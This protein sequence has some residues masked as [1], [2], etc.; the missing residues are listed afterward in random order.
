MA[1]EP[2]TAVLVHGGFVDGS[3]WQGVYN[4]LRRTAT[5]SASFRTRRRRW[6]TTSPRPDASSTA[7][8]ARSILVG[9]SYGGVVITEAGNDPRSQGSSTSPRSRRTRASRSPRSSRTRRPARRCRRSCRRRTDFCSSTRTKFPPR[10]RRTCEPE[11]RVHGRLAGALGRRGTQR[12]DHEAGVEDQAE[13]VPGRD[14]GQDDPAAGAAIHVR[15]ARAST[16]EEAA[17][18]HAIY[19]SKPKAVA[20]IIEKA[21]GNA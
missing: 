8:M 19:V 2:G 13:L 10:S 5:P 4:I 17:G 7:R 12:R 21:L 16:V 15:S 9:H 3:G 20:A 6:R 11:G 18:S 1:S 14:R